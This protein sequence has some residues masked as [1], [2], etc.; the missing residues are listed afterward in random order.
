MAQVYT[1]LYQ[2]ICAA[3]KR[4]AQDAVPAECGCSHVVRHSWIWICEC[5][6][7]RPW[8]LVR[9]GPLSAVP[10]R[11][12]L[13]GVVGPVISEPPSEGL[14]RTPE[15]KA[16]G[17]IH[18]WRKNETPNSLSLVQLAAFTHLSP[19]ATLP[20]TNRARRRLTPTTLSARPFRQETGRGPSR[21]SKASSHEDERL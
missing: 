12:R 7:S 5:S 3:V 1:T 20:G 4:C 14:G 11:C 19:A 18:V 8:P 2:S 21:L 17:R 15:A 9:V 6:R 10:D 16:P 13:L